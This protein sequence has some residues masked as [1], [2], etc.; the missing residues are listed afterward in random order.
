MTT[1]VTK[2]SDLEWTG[3]PL[4]GG[5]VVLAA[6][7]PPIA[8]APGPRTEE[9]SIWRVRLDPDCAEV[10]AAG[11]L[12]RRRAG[13]S[14]VEDERFPALCE[15]S[16][17]PVLAWL[18]RDRGRE[19]PWRLRV[20]PVEFDP[21]SGEPIVRD[22]SA[23][24]LAEDCAAV[25]PAFSPDGLWITYVPAPLA[26]DRPRVRRLPVAEPAGPREAA[27]AAAPAPVGGVVG[28]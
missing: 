18:G 14:R 15:A 13:A 26:P 2:V 20:A 25:A 16:G 10:V 4:A 28:G 11:P 7:L 5:H 17:A 27:S 12:A 1:R 22:E 21:A 6:V 24:T 19:G 8:D 9:W 23:R 3:G